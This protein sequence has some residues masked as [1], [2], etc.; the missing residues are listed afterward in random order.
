MRIATGLA[1]CVL[2][3]FLIAS[4]A[5]PLAAQDVVAGADLFLEY[6]A[7]C[8]GGAAEGDGPMAS[9][10]L[11]QPSNLTTL[12]QRNDGRFPVERIVTRIDGRDPLVSHG[13]D[14][15]VYGWFFEGSDVTFKT[16]SGQPVMTSA[17]IAD[18]LEF[19]RSVQ[20]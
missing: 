16:P 20:K 18:I 3:P 19:L 5:G 17:P 6:C 4:A 12:T 13:S 1:T 14:M 10:L 7:A 8:H 2:A 9:A 15:P 11:V